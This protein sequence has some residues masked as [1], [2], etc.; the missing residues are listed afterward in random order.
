MTIIDDD[1][2]SA[3]SV[4]HLFRVSAAVEGA[5]DQGHIGLSLLFARVMRLLDGPSLDRSVCCWDARGIYQ[6]V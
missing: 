2:L 6:P 1:L 5:N 3:A 4:K